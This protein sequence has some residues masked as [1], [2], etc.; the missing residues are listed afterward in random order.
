MASRGHS[1]V[2]LA[3]AV[4]SPTTHH[5]RRSFV[6]A[7]RCH[8][9]TGDSFECARTHL[10]FGERLRGARRRTHARHELRR[11][12]KVYD[13]LGAAPRAERARLD[14]LATGETA[15]R[16]VRDP[17]DRLPP[18]AFQIARMLAGG[19]TTRETPT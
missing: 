17:L 6:E 14:L 7:L 19:A 2:P 12:L 18:Q 13:E 10:C 16:R 5:S 15:R 4:L 3:A 9:S 11:A 8:E 1:R